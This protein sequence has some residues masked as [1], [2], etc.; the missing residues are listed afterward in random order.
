MNETRLTLLADES[1]VR[2]LP[3]LRSRLE[4]VGRS[5]LP[6]NFSSILDE[7][8]RQVIDKAVESAGGTE[9]SVW[10]ADESSESLVIVYNT[11]PNS[12]RLVGHFKQPLGAGLISMVFASEQPFIENHVFKNSRQ[13]KSLD[14]MLSLQTHAMIAIPFYFLDT[15]RGVISCVQLTATG[16]MDTTPSGFD[17]DDEAIVRNA[18]VILGRLIDHWVL[19]TMVGLA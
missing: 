2:L 1:F 5:I 6:Q 15:L 12:D 10:L 11:G 16:S 4:L 13:D 9:G 19:R 14:S 17:H 7:V 3:A 18:T 8:M